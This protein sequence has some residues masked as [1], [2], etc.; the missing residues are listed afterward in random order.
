MAIPTRDPPDDGS[1]LSIILPNYNHGALIGRAI[2]AL[3]SQERGADEIIIVDDA[4]TDNSLAVIEAYAAKCPRISVLSQPTNL[5]TAAALSKGLE[6]ARGQ[7]VYF[8]AADDRVLPGFFALALRMLE[9]HGATGLFCGEAVLID[10][11]TDRP[12]G[13]RPA[14]RP[15]YRAGARTAAQAHHLMRRMDNWILTGSTVFRREAITGAGGL[16]DRLGSFADGFLVRKIALTMGFCYAP[17]LVAAWHVF[18]SGM[19]RTTALDPAKARR[20]LEFFPAQIAGDPAFPAWYAEL[21]RRRWR[22]A[23][24]RLAAEADD[25]DDEFIASMVG[26]SQLDRIALKAIRSACRGRS[27][28]VAILAWSWLRLRPYRLR[29]IAMTTMIRAA[30]R[31]WAGVRGS[32]SRTQRTR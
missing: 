16:D 30:E 19:S 8:G 24:V 29:D 23:T 22:F 27:R 31:L 10:G 13:Y 12:I 3:L 6:R 2:E 1:T 28:R 32:V 20:A 14:A 18:A 4:S 9:E 11:A 25:A 17:Q 15:L 26:T 5:G 21:F 7:Y